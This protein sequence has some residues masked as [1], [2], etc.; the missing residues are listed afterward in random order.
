MQLKAGE[1][2]RQQLRGLVQN[3]QHRVTDVAAQQASTPIGQQHLV[4]HRC[5]G[6]L[7]IGAGDH[8]PA[9]RRTVTTRGIQPPG[10]LHIAPDRYPGPGRCGQHGSC[11]RES[12]ARHHQG[13]VGDAGDGPGRV[14]DGGALLGEDAQ[15]IDIVITQRRRHAEG[16]QRRQHG[17]SGHPG[18]GH[19]HRGTRGQQGEIVATAAPAGWARHHQ[20]PTAVSHSL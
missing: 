6:G 20:A 13:V 5:G 4:Q 8:Q 16:R 18:T 3:S 9:P 1:L 7:A 11:G 12:R 10:Q 2:D 17:P 14:D 15:G 19:Q